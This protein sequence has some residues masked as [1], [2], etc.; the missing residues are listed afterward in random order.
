M[1]WLYLSIEIVTIF[2]TNHDILSDS[3]MFSFYFG[4]LV[5]YIIAQKGLVQEFCKRLL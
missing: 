1:I 5:C 4:I 3:I 2:S